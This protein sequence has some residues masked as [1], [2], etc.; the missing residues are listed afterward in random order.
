MSSNENTSGALVFWRLAFS[1]CGTPDQV[2]DFGSQAG[3]GG[4]PPCGVVVATG[5]Q[6]QHTLEGLIRPE[7]SAFMD[8]E[9]TGIVKNEAS[10]LKKKRD[11]SENT[12]VQIHFP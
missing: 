9:G 8:G 4:R 1:V 2:A 11:L 3:G 10:V 7:Q 12:Q 5:S 6:R